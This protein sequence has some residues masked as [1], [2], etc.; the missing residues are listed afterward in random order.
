M[1]SEVT[2]WANACAAVSE[3]AIISQETA[4]FLTSLQP[5]TNPGLP[6]PGPKVKV[7]DDIYI[8]KMKN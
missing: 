4:A 8:N 2:S 3:K 6:A 5:A 1:P 7:H